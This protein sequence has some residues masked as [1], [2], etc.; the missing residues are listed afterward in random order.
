MATATRSK[1]KAKTEV[2]V[3]NVAYI[4]DMSGSMGVVESATKEGTAQY[5]VD[6]QAEEKKLAKKSGKV[7]THL[8]LTAFD[9][10]FE[11]WVVNEPIAEID[12]NKLVGRYHPRGGTALYDAIANTI[13]EIEALLRKEA[14]ESEKVLVIVMTD[15]AE[16][17][18]KDYAA[19]NDGRARIFQL[20]K[21]YEAKGNWTFVYLGANVDAYAEAGAMGISPGNTASYAATM[22]SVM[23]TGAS[24]S[25]VTASR[26]ASPG[27][28]TVTAFADAGQPQDYRDPALGA[29]SPP[30][31]TRWKR[32]PAELPYANPSKAS[33]AS[34]SARG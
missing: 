30:R 24:L 20:I 7:F 9:T 12:V 16:N 33:D 11:P 28:Q 31:S 26:R 15:G 18:S 17:A 25:Q 10:V 6:L 14:R 8:S 13:T 5:L 21:S 3:L 1:R 23:A 4:W 32:P 2:N 27:G 34:K 29:P 19:H 22:D